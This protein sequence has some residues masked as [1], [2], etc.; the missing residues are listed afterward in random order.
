[1]SSHRD[2]ARKLTGV[3]GFPITPMNADLSVDYD[4][5]GKLVDWMTQYPFCAQVTAGGTGEMTM[6]VAALLTVCMNWGAVDGLAAYQHLRASGVCVSTIANG[7]PTFSRAY[8]DA[9]TGE[10]RLRANSF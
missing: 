9:V 3:F 1:M 5:L 6:F 7:I 10:Y 4:G 8:G 2:F